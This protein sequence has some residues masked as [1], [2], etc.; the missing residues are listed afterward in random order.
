MELEDMDFF[1]NKYFRINRGEEYKPGMIPKKYKNEKLEEETISSFF[2]T[3]HNDSLGN[4]NYSRHIKYLNREKVKESLGLNDDEKAIEYFKNFT[5]EEISETFGEIPEVNLEELMNKLSKYF[6]ST[7]DN[8]IK[9]LSIRDAYEF[10][11]SKKGKDF[12]KSKDRSFTP[13]EKMLECWLKYHVNYLNDYKKSLKKKT[14]IDFGSLKKVKKILS[15]PSVK[16]LK[17][18]KKI[19]SVKQEK[20]NKIIETEEPS[21]APKKKPPVNTSR[22]PKKIKQEKE[23][24]K[25]K[26]VP[27]GIPKKAPKEELVSKHGIPPASTLPNLENLNKKAEEFDRKFAQLTGKKAANISQEPGNKPK[28]PTTKA[29]KLEPRL[30]KTKPTN[31]NNPPAVK[32][33]EIEDT[34]IG[35][36]IKQFTQ[37]EPKYKFREAI[38]EEDRVYQDSFD[39]LSEEEKLMLEKSDWNENNAIEKIAK[40]LAEKREKPDYD[41][42]QSLIQASW[43]QGT[44]KEQEEVQPQT[45]LAG[46]EPVDLSKLNPPKKTSSDTYE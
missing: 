37:S 12:L 3:M 20:P 44:K 16:K 5:L 40:F 24:P 14:K 11:K 35:E 33:S 2:Y 46:P 23:A 45:S 6:Q 26:L 32:T 4:G 9:Y 31:L 22:P 25:K 8:L 10:F 19:K 13:E 21:I 17:I 36:Q 1:L 43:L 15:I 7:H 30:V 38:F 27:S 42:D 41:K 39:E 28:I 18:K 34:L 29:P